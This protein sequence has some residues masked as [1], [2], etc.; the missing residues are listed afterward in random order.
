MEKITKLEDLKAWE[1]SRA[2]LKLVYKTTA[3]FP[4][5]EKYNLT[6]HMRECSRNIPG[7]IGE[8]FGRFHYQESMQFYRIARGSLIELKSDSYCSYDLG[9]TDKEKLELL[10]DQ[11]EKVGKPLNGL[12]KSAIKVKYTN[13]K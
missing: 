3:Q 2:L 13:N 8:A 9:Y 5:E 7:N 12:I 10:I 6:K 1:E 11:N 4:S